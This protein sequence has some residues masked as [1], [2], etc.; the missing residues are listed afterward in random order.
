MSDAML[1]HITHANYAWLGLSSPP[2][3][4]KD[5]RLVVTNTDVIL[6]LHNH[7]V[8]C[9]ALNRNNYKHSCALNR[10]ILLPETGVV[11]LGSDPRILGTLFV[12]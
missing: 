5:M 1:C 7:V 4:R 3:P 11:P 10:K 6:L 12:L 2:R 8:F 9:C